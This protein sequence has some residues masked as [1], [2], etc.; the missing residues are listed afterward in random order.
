MQIEDYGDFQAIATRLK[1]DWSKRD[2]QIE[3]MRELRFMENDLEYPLDIEPEEV[4]VPEGHQLIERMVGTLTADP[5]GVTVPP[6]DETGKAQENSSKVEKFTLAALKQ[7]EQQADTDVIDRFVETLIADGHGC[8]RMLYAPQLWRKQPRKKKGE[9]EDEHND[10]VEHWQKGKGLPIA[11]NWI[12]PLTVYPLWGEF[13]LEA[14]LEEDER[15]ILTLHPERW[16]VSKPDLRELSRIHGGNTQSVTFQ[17]LWTHDEVIYAV[18]GEIV[19]KQQHEYSTPPYAYAFGLGAA[20]NDPGYMGHSI[21]YPVRHLLPYEDRL[22]SQKGTAIR[23]WGWPTVVTKVQTQLAASGTAPTREIE[24]APGKTVTLYEDEEIG[25]LGWR[26]SAPDVDEQLQ[27][28]DAK[29]KRA[30][31][32]DPA[33]GIDTG[34]SG[35]AINQLIAASRMRYK[36]IVA[37]AERAIEQQIQ[38]LWDIIEYQI[39][40]PVHVFNYGEQGG[41]VSLAPDDLKG[42]RQVKATL[43]PVMPTDQYATSSRA[44]NEVSGG[45][46]G[47][48]SAMEMIGIEQP[49]E[50]QRRIRVDRWMNQPEID[51]IMT[52]EA[53]KRLGLELKKGGVTPGQIEESYP[54]LP[55]ALQQE[56]GGAFEATAPAGHSAT[57]L[58]MSPA[59]EELPQQLQDAVRQIAAAHGATPEQTLA[60]LV[61]MAQNNDMRLEDV[62]MAML[63]QIQGQQGRT[64]QTPPTEGEGVMAAPG[65]RAIP[66]NRH[67]GRSTR[68]SGVATG[69]APGQRQ[70]GI[71]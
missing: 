18:E 6:A 12:D 49:D 34:Q 41:W 69:R 15:D 13:G 64:G 53:V 4:R 20:I 25:F 65:V 1:R 45:L 21:L 48:T 54:N 71:E 51:K 67:Y 17:Q 46:R 66:E 44:L 29:I 14:I 43:N 11:W 58:G 68:P 59:F 61:E 38:R 19:H 60:A 9:S 57:E 24:I 30:G 3:E 7:L 47:R 36:P 22:L 63:G 55:P 23:I 32:P 52:R 10:R 16:N 42:Y 31:L 56:I 37:H 35:Y 40:A 27:I 50:E 33:L 26:G 2:K 62:I 70:E 8:M 5:I 28:I 39:K